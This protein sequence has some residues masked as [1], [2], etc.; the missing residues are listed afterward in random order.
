MK[1]RR[2]KDKE[3]W[4]GHGRRLEKNVRKKSRAI[5]NGQNLMKF[6][7]LCFLFLSGKWAKRNE[8]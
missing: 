6:S 7:V 5:S 3:G 8:Y 2:R 4:K 1:G